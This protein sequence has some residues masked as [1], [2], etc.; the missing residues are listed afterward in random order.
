MP[1]PA[2][3]NPRWTPGA[4][5]PRPGRS[6][7]SPAAGQTG[8]PAPAG[9]YPA[10]AGID[11]STDAGPAAA[12]GPDQRAS[13]RTSPA[14]AAD[15]IHEPQLSGARMGTPDFERAGALR[16]PLPLVALSHTV[17]AR[18]RPWIRAGGSSRPGESSRSQRPS[19]LCPPG[20]GR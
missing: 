7:P 17:P 20:G 11:R 19:T 2:A 9:Q 15:P 13:P 8:S 16:R 1:A 18:W 4:V 12:S 5:G 10:P 14:L 3:P 6:Y